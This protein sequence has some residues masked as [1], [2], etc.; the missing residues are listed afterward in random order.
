MIIEF[1]RKGD[2]HSAKEGC[3]FPVMKY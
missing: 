3:E 1:A 2:K